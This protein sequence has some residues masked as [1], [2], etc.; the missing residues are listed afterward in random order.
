M[1]N[2]RTNLYDF[3][4]DLLTHIEE[5]IKLAKTDPAVHQ[6]AT[7]AECGSAVSCLMTRL[8]TNKFEAAQ[9]MLVYAPIHTSYWRTEWEKLATAS[10]QDFLEGADELL[11]G[12]ALLKTHFENR[13]KASLG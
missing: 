10:L 12:A 8:A 1:G 3:A 6:Q 2:W 11:A 7:I 9:T 4:I 13:I 5:Q